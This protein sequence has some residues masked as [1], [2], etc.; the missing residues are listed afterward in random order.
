MLCVP[1]HVWVALSTICFVQSGAQAEAR[2]TR[3]RPLRVSILGEGKMVK[4]GKMRVETK[5]SNMEADETQGNEVWE[6]GLTNIKKHIKR[7]HRNMIFQPKEK[8]QHWWYEKCRG[9]TQS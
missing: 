8:S 4:S 3:N 6:R 5:G 2:K 9:Y 1:S 7:L